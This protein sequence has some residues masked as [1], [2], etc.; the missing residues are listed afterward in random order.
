MPNTNPFPERILLAVPKGWA[1][2]LMRL[3][4]KHETTRA[5]LLRRV[6]VKFLEQE[7]KAP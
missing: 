5:E 2:R 7:E 4:A 6:L 1:E 3:A